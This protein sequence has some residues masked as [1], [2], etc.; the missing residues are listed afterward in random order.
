MTTATKYHTTELGCSCPDW[1]YRGARGKG[2]CKH[3]RALKD[4]AGLGVAGPGGARRGED[5]PSVETQ[6]GNCQ[7]CAKPH[8]DIGVILCACGRHQGCQSTIDPKTYRMLDGSCE[9]ECP[10]ACALLGRHVGTC[11]KST[12]NTQ[13]RLV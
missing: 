1:Y 4:E 11:E 6:R 10:R 5:S 2:D 9:N 13:R 3:M 8:S 12:K 7:F